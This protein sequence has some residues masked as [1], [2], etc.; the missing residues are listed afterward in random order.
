MPSNPYVASA[1]SVT[2]TVNYSIY[3]GVT[4][5]IVPGNYTASFTCKANY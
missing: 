2:I 3:A 5:P 4:A 1:G